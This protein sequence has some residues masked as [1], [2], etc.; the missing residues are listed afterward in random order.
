MADTTAEYT[1]DSHTIC[2]FKFEDP[3]NPAH[4]EGTCTKTFQVN[5][6]KIDT[7]NQKIGSGCVNMNNS[8]LYCP[9]FDETIFNKDFTVDCWINTD[10]FGKKE[11]LVHRFFC[12][13]ENSLKANKF[14]IIGYGQFISWSTSSSPALNIAITNGFGH[15]GPTSPEFD[16]FSTPITS[17]VSNDKWFHLAMVRSSNKLNMFING[18]FQKSVDWAYTMADKTGP[19]YIGIRTIPDGGDVFIE[20]METDLMD[21]FRISDFARFNREFDPIDD[22]AGTSGKSYISLYY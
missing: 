3:S 13:G 20:S 15:S 12:L 16:Q 7:T 6:V 10:C 4:Y 14:L 9:D 21:N 11:N 17:E 22:I 18:K 19:F 5:N 8:Y 1:V 2:L